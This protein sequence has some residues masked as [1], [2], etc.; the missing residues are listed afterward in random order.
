MSTFAWN[1]SSGTEGGSM[2][3]QLLGG[4][5]TQHHR[6][7]PSFDW[8]TARSLHNG[9]RLNKPDPN[10]A[11]SVEY[12]VSTINVDTEWQRRVDGY[13]EHQQRLGGELL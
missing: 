9:I 6:A 7:Y 8:D 13:V 1:D 11:V 12:L 2:N 4:G 10:G 3:L 5:Y